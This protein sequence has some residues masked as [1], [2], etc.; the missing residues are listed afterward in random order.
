MKRTHTLALLLIFAV[1][2]GA[3]PIQREFQ[4]AHGII[5][6]NDAAVMALDFGILS[7]DEGALLQ[8]GTQGVTEALNKAIKARRGG[9]VIGVIDALLTAV[10]DSLLKVIVQLE[11]MKKGDG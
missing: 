6:T 1:G 3:T 8:V 10:E 2:C 9:A 5:D 7:A 4:I 11:K